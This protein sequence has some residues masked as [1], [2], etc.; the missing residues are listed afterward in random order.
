MSCAACSA[1]VESAVRGL[2]GVVSCS[3]NLLTADMVVEGDVSAAEIRHA[4]V[5]SGY[6]IIDDERTLDDTVTPAL[7]KRLIYSVGFL[8][9]L[10]Y[11]SMGRMWGFPQ[12][13]LLDEYPVVTAL[14]QCLLS[15]VILIINRRFFVNGVRGVLNLA[16]NM[17]TLVSLGSAVSFAYSVYLT[18]VMLIE[19]NNG[20]NVNHY[21]HNLYFESSAM[22]LVLITVGKTLEA[23]AKGKTTSALRSLMELSPKTATLLRDGCEVVVPIDDVKVGDVFIVRPGQSIPTDAVVID[24]SGAVDE[25]ALTGESIPVDKEAGSELFASTI[26]KYGVLTAR[27]TRVGEGTAISGIIAMVKEASASK[28]PIAKLADKVS[29]VFVPVVIAI[30][31]ATLAGW[32]IAAKTLGFALARAISVVVISCPCALGLATPVAIMVGT[33]VG[34]KNGVLYKNAASLEECGRVDT[35]ILDK[36]GT[37][38]QG[39]PTVTD[40]MPFGG[41]SRCELLGIAA[42]L[43][44]GS[45]H[46]LG[47]AIAEYGR[48]NGVPTR[49]LTDFAALSGRGVRGRV[50]GEEIYG[51]SFDYISGLM[52]VPDDVRLDYERLANDGKTPLLFTKNGEILGIIALADKIKGDSVGAIDL[53]KRMGIKVVMLTGD[54]ERT[55]ASIAEKVKI[56]TVVAGVLPDGKRDVVME[57]KR[58]GRVAMVGDGINDAVALT[59]ANVGIAIGAGAD[60]AIDA[61]DVVLVSHALFAV[62]NALRLGRSV[63]TNVKE[64]LFWA[65][66]YNIIGIPLAIGLFGLS[67]DPMFAAAAMSLSSVCVVM[68]ALRLGLWKARECECDK[69]IM[70]K[71]VTDEVKNIENSPG[72]EENIVKREY[73]VNG[74]M[75]PHCEA[76][77]KSVCEAIDGVLSATPSHKT[78]TVE[79][80]C[81]ESVNDEAVIGAITAAGYEVV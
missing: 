77:V 66:I 13:R 8:L 55:A 44:G 12:P 43:E 62:P 40:V 81:L 63:L 25:S 61:A 1:R 27:S 20:V 39:K 36:T 19:S 49:E 68:N 37:I 3:V 46:P 59:E 31:L 71:N 17:D 74:M 53:L 69:M 47:R 32:L 16:P 30:S 15:G 34:A 50:N 79:I 29:G 14:L 58:N 52:T 21:L 9:L 72:K 23:K 67:L 56:D 18:V 33:G 51:A 42:T 22:I 64:N 26:N 48:E 80:E 54:N 11:I 60:V 6:E 70:K 41:A 45:E 7:I 28:A 73:K 2:P 4:V 75:C 38:T 35:V 10:M 24:G 78:A 5:S 65:F 76:R 57:Y